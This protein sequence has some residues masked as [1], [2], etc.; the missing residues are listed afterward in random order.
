MPAV[1]TP[2]LVPPPRRRTQA[3]IAL[4]L[5]AIL[6]ILQSKLLREP[7]LGFVE[8]DNALNIRQILE[9]L[10][11]GLIASYALWR[12]PRLAL[13]ANATGLLFLGFAFWTCLTAAWS[14]GPGLTAL[15]AVEFAA[16]TLLI[17]SLLDAYDD[18]ADGMLMLAWLWIALAIATLVGSVV[19]WAPD[20]IYE[21]TRST[22]DGFVAAFVIGA[23]LARR[24]PAAQTFLTIGVLVAAL[25]FYRSIGTL[26]AAG[27]VSGLALAIVFAEAFVGRRPAAVGAGI[28][29]LLA[30][31]LVLA[32]LAGP[33]LNVIGG[34]FDRELNSLR[35]LTGRTDIWA[36]VIPNLLA[37]PQVLLVG[38]GHVAGDRIMV[39]D[40]VREA[41][42]A[43]LDAGEHDFGLAQHTHNLV[44]GAIANIGLIGL[45]LLTALYFVVPVAVLARQGRGR[46]LSFLVVCLAFI[47]VNGISE[48]ILSH[49]NLLATGTLAYIL[50][51]TRRSV[52]RR[53]DDRQRAP[54]WRAT[55]AHPLPQAAPRSVPTGR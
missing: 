28:L 10:A 29:L 18:P 4:G 8:I 11:I 20:N 55:A 21:A 38:G 22:I 12:L 45:G 17:L 37:D 24:R 39:F 27:V 46:E 19:L 53:V 6:Y 15:R 43:T 40:W 30:A 49:A 2:Y 5:L 9:V 7:D 47:L 31:I 51:T 50:A 26:V 13:S 34:L 3:F 25:I 35:S 36:I 23:L 52:H 16:V 1:D 33:A 42:R 41:V 44:L 32:P 54:S 48:N 14:F